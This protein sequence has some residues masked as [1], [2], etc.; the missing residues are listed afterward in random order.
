[1]ASNDDVLRTLDAKITETQRELERLKRAAELLPIVS[2]NLQALQRSRAILAG[3]NPDVATHTEGLLDTGRGMDGTRAVVSGSV[4]VL[5]VEILKE[6]GKA[7]HAKKLT[8]RI[9]AKGKD[10]N[11]PTVVGTLVRY[12]KT[13]QLRRTAPNTFGLAKGAT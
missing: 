1:M 5:A 9:R 10:V 13:G 8:E 12:V 7:M 6:S 2:T 3:E 11:L 4:G